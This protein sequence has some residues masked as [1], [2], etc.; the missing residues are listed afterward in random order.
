[1]SEARIRVRANRSA[2]ELE[3]EGTSQAV[4]EWR[5]KLWPELSM[6]AQL[7][8]ILPQPGL[9]QA[10]LPATGN[11]QFPDVFSEFFS[12]FRSDVTDVYKAVI[13]WALRKDTPVE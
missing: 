7:H 4:S 8:A 2:G 1:M 5:D 12:G 6:G 10:H 11:G 3:V 13:A 9:R